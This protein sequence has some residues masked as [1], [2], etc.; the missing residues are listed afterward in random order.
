MAFRIILA[1][2]V[3]FFQG[4]NGAYWSVIIELNEIPEKTNATENLPEADQQLFESLR[5][6]RKGKAGE[7]RNR[8]FS[9]PIIVLHG[10]S[11][12]NNRSLGLVESSKARM[13][14]L[15]DSS[16][17]SEQ[18]FALNVTDKTSVAKPLRRSK[19]VRPTW[20]SPETE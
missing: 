12:Q 18:R 9:G 1:K 13:V 14:F 6:Y 15:S 17:K 10:I 2:K 11:H 3:R 20:N 19:H 4:Q 16:N 7:N 8:I 5:E